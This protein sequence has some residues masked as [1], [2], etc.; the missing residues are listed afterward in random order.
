MVLTAQ[1][2][3]IPRERQAAV[4]GVGVI[5][6]N[7]MVETRMARL[8]KRVFRAVKRGPASRISRVSYLGRQPWEHSELPVSG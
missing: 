4:A 3:E 2:F 7:G 6:R 8:L 5:E 1:V